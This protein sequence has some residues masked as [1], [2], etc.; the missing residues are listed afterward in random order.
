MA[1][2]ATAPAHTRTSR[3]YRI[4]ELFQ[5]YRVREVKPGQWKIA[6]AERQCELLPPEYHTKELAEA[7]ARMQAACDIAELF[8]GDAK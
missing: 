1:D 6:D 2:T 3:I 8:D 5:R 7:G 4:A